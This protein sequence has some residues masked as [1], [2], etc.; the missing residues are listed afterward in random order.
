MA[1]FP[2]T[3]SVPARMIEVGDVVYGRQGTY[4]GTW[5]LFKHA[6]TVTEVTP[7]GAYGVNAVGTHIGLP[8]GPRSDV[9]IAREGI[10]S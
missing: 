3:V 6:V 9:L 5:Q 4:N 1:S 8:S 10:R 2:A 7:A